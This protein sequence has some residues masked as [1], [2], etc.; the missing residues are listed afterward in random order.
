MKDSIIAFDVDGTIYGSP[1]SHKGEPVLNL[2]TVQLMQLLKDHVK[3]CRVI[4]WSG[5]GQEYAEQ[6]VTKFG[7]ERYIDRCYGKHEY[8][9]TIDG[10]VALAFDDE[11]IFDMAV[12]NLIV[13][14]K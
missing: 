9:E 6:I 14:T 1:F 2:K 3:N 4:V 8:D 7:L 12:V 10:K 5:G 11:Y 13:K